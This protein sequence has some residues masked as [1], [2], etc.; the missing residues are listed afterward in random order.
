MKRFTLLLLLAVSITTGFGQNLKNAEV[1][2]YGID[3]SKVKVYGAEE[4]PSQFLDAFHSINRLFLAEA[5]KY[6][7]GKR[8]Q[9]YVKG[10]DLDPVEA[11]NDDIEK[12]DLIQ[13]GYGGYQLTDEDIASAIRQLPI[14][15]E[16]GIGLVFIAEVLNKSSQ[17][18]KYCV[19]FFD[20]ESRDVIDVWEG[21]GKAQGF[22]LRNYWARSVYNMM[23]SF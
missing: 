1:Y 9:V 5:D 7:V 16:S 17:R 15:E 14:K 6:N 4:S 23:K 13:N 12:A 3:F 11:V 10:I 8:L 22:G 2:F 19:T 21:K 18:A 20:I